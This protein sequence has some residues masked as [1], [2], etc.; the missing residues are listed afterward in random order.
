MSAPVS[1]DVRGAVE[2]WWRAMADKDLA[3]LEALAL[4]DYRVSRLAGDCRA[5]TSRS[6]SR[7]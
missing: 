6:S 1:A 2:A 5:A 7:M 4:P 3:A